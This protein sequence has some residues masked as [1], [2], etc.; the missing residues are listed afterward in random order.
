MDA[1]AVA[2]TSWSKLPGID[3]GRVLG[4]TYQLMMGRCDE[5]ARLVTLENGKPYEEARKE[6]TF[7]AGWFI[8]SPRSSSSV[9]RNRAVTV[10]Q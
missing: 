3:R 1:A 10:H 6:V 2:F 5:I 4:K 7:A 9:W 8:G